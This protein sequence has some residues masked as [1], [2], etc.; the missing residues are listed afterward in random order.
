M[1]GRFRSRKR[2]QRSVSWENDFFNSSFLMVAAELVVLVPGLRWSFNCLVRE[3][4]TFAI[5]H[6]IKA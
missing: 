3:A 1:V 6:D 4:T 2:P 5:G